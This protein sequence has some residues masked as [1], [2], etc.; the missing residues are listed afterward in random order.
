MNIYIY[1][2]ELKLVTFNFLKIQI[3]NIKRSY[4]R[5]SRSV[6]LM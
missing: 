5:R 6:P 1:K 3:Y 4:E 2:N